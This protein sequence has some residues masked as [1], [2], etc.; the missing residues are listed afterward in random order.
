MYA[1]DHHAL[2]VIV[3]LGGA[4]ALGLGEIAWLF[5][6]H[7]F[8]E[9]MAGAHP[10]LS[11]GSAEGRFQVSNERDVSVKSARVSVTIP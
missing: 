11:A 1:R 9:R 8:I 7:R 2:L 10:A 4:A 5:T 3:T 6:A